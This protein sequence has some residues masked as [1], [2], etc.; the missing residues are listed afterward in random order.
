[1]PTQN[2]NASLVQ[3]ENMDIPGIEMISDTVEVQPIDTVLVA[4]EMEVAPKPKIIENPVMKLDEPNGVVAP[5]MSDS[6][7]LI[8]T[9]LTNYNQKKFEEAC[10]VLVDTKCDATSEGSVARFGEELEKMKNGYQNISVR[11]VE[12]PDF[13]SD[14]VCVEYDY[15]YISSSNTNPIHETLSFYVQDGKITY[16]ICE[17]KTRDGETIGC[18]IQS[19]RDFCLE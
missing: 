19:R 10:E 15:R 9:F 12:V 14:V 11:Q 7:E 5:K 3:E 4:D 8:Y 16:R 18:P 13:H 2:D 6:E 1:M 17:D